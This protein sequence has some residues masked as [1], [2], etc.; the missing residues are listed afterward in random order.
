MQ[1]TPFEAEGLSK[2]YPGGASALD[3]VC[4]RIEKPGELAAVAGPDGS[5]KTTLL[6]C[7]AGLLSADSGS[8]SV[9]GMNP[10]PASDEFTS[11]IGFM[12]Q[13]FSLYP[14]LTVRENFFFFS[15]L[16]GIYDE[17]ALERFSDWMKRTDLA[18]FADRRA[19]K[20]SGGMKQKLGLA[21]ALVHIPK[22]LIL[23][24][25][26]VGVDPLSRL[27]LFKLIDQLRKNEGV[28]VLMSTPYL[29]EAA[30]ADKTLI[31]DQGRPLGFKPPSEWIKS[32]EGRTF[33]VLPEEGCGPTRNL[34]RRLLKS[35]C[36][37]DP[38]S[39]IL[40][41]VPV[42]GAVNI[43][44]R[45]GASAESSCRSEFRLEPRRPILEDAYSDA[46][47]S[48]GKTDAKPS[49][50]I[51]SCGRKSIGTHQYAVKA[52]GLSMAF[53]SFKA[54][55]DADF[56]VEK[57]EVFGLLGPN[58]AGKTTTFRMLCGLLAPTSGSLLVAG[59]DVKRA[60]SE[61][62][63]RIGYVAQ[64]FSLYDRLTPRENLQYFAALYGL[65]SRQCRERI[66]E[67]TQNGTLKEM[68][69]VRC[70]FLPL[71]AKRELSLAA[72]LIHKPEILFLDEPTSG[73][74]L[75]SRRR[76]WRRIL[77]LAESGTTVIATT[78]FLEEAEYFDK[79]VVQDSGRILIASTPEDARSI[80][81]AS[82]IEEAFIKVVRKAR[83]INS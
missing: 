67:L 73:A 61:L 20:L 54:V 8:I 23:D 63:R 40:D 66:E 48:E 27:E 78:H 1:T 4:I 58:G 41:A 9:F 77:D 37:T 42:G 13:N 55:D 32:V 70:E 62:R 24:E 45:R 83:G 28:S 69:D 52:E 34:A 22:L 56:V 43:L 68:L 60:G 79:F 50:Q 7:A 16:R 2:T 39:P 80:D 3:K 46:V 81:G 72:A 35:T 74:D 57:G 71:G 11:S 14:K 25:P 31:L 29:S 33:R 76:F 65:T 30:A 10:D 82:S 36:Q 75:S 12:P 53:G 6:K 21:C 15:A 49:N 5:G 26:T 64:K 51:P 44:L 19:E 18:S 17:T 47:L 59:V 38:E